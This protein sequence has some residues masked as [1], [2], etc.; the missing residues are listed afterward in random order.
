MVNMSTHIHKQQSSANK[1]GG[2][3]WL[4]SGLGRQSYLI[5]LILLFATTCTAQT[6]R[7][8]QESQ[9]PLRH[10]A[11]RIRVDTSGFNGALDGT[12]VNVQIALDVLDGS[13]PISSFP[14][15]CEGSPAAFDFCFYYDPGEE[16]VELWVNG[17]EEQQWPSV[18][19]VNLLLLETGDFLLLE[20]GTSKLK[21]E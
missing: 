16:V 13:V 9:H 19:T 6:Y 18:A 5:A 11:D 15:G 2:R 1:L 4:R 14:A 17:T 12:V 3:C 20:D 8:R 21:L 10:R 7:V